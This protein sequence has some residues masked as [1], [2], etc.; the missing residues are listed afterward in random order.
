M[1]ARVARADSWTTRQW[2]CPKAP[3]PMT[4]TRGCDIGGL[5][6]GA[7]PL[8]LGSPL[9]TTPP[10]ALE[11]AMKLMLLGK[12]GARGTR[13][14]RRG[15]PGG[16]APPA[17]SERFNKHDWVG[18]SGTQGDPR[19]PGGPPHPACPTPPGLRW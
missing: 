18:E 19:G 5:P 15:P 4:A 17:R 7:D 2:F 12:S 11:V 3:A 13:A 6:C 9:G 8:V 14:G 1:A 10:S 16:A